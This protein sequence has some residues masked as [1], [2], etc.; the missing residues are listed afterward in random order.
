MDERTSLTRLYDE[1]E[2][3]RILK[4][5]TE[6]HR[7]E[8]TG[9]RSGG[10]LTLKDLEE[11]AAEAGI[12]PERLRRAAF[13]I[14]QGG[15]QGTSQWRWLVG[16]ATTLV[17]ERTIAGELPDEAF[18]QVVAVI[19]ESSLDY[20]QPSLLGRTL[21]WRAETPT[22]TR[23]I[24]VVVSS[25]N[26]Q[27]HIRVEERLHQL[28]GG[29]FGGIT[30]GVGLGVGMGV[31]VPVGVAALGSVTFAFAFPLGITALSYLGA[32]EIYRVLVARRR[33]ILSDL[34]ARLAETVTANV[35]GEP[36]KLPPPG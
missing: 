13:E 24:Q 29:L 27:T 21:T 12:D 2:V 11:I 16:E 8:S 35:A 23:S 31:G 10:G 36:D 20:G 3:A 18:E 32:R 1:D 17:Y 22:K 33:S 9:T 34:A 5:A 25:R 7:E 19:Q 14:D 6:L 15:A 4:R 28:A 26:G 30:A